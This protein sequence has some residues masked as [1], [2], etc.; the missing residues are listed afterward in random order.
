[1][2]SC[3]HPLPG[4]PMIAQ[5][6]CTC[7]GVF[8]LALACVRQLFEMMCIRVESI[9]EAVSEVSVTLAVHTV[10]R[11]AFVLAVSESLFARAD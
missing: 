10:K 5:T 3:A 11:L 2:Q 4:M 7:R 8:L 1:M 6:S 9:A